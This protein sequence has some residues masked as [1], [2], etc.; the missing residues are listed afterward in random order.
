MN[1]LGAVAHTI[2]IRGQER[3]LSQKYEIGK[4][5]VKGSGDDLVGEP[6]GVGTGNS[7]A[8]VLKIKACPYFKSIQYSA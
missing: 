4:V 5:C 7:R 1:I 6:L 3:E 8:M 2:G